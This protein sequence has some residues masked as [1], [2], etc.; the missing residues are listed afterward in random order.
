MDKGYVYILV[1]KSMPGL[2]KIGRTKKN[3]KDRAKEL[4]STTGVPTPF[5][6]AYALCSFR[7]ESLEKQIHIELAN[8]RTNNNRE[9]FETSVDEAKKLLNKLASPI[10]HAL[11]FF[12]NIFPWYPRHTREDTYISP[13]TGKSIIP[14]GEF[15]IE[16]RTGTPKVGIN[17]NHYHSADN[18]FD[19]AK[20]AN[21]IPESV[22][23]HINIII[24]N[25]ELKIN[26]DHESLKEKTEKLSDEIEGL[27]KER[28]E[29]EK[30]VEGNQEVLTDNKLLLDKLTAAS[31][32]E[33][34]IDENTEDFNDKKAALAQLQSDF[35]G[36]P[37]GDSISRPRRSLRLYRLFGVFCV[38]LSFAL[39]FFYI[40][41]IDKGYLS[42]LPTPSESQ[43]IDLERYTQLNDIFDPSSVFRAFQK[44]NLWLIVFPFFA[45]GLA[46]VI[47][48][49]LTYGGKYQQEGKKKTAILCWLSVFLF[50]I[51]TF[52]F[53]CILALQVS[54]KIHEA[55]VLF[56][57]EE[58]DWPID[59]I[60]PSTWD[61]NIWLVLFCGF[62]VSVLL[63][64]LFHF[65]LEMWK[66][67]QTQDV[68]DEIR[69]RKEIRA[70]ETQLKGQEDTIRERQNRLNR[71]KEELKSKYNEIDMSALSAEI[72]KCE[73]NIEHLI[74]RINQGKS[75]IESIKSE[76]REKQSRIDDLNALIA[77]KAIDIVKL[78][79]N[80]SEFVSGWT[81]FLAAAKG[82]ASEDVRTV[83]KIAESTLEKYFQ[84]STSL[85]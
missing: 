48:P 29:A 54:K 78:R 35:G 62:L 67:A 34:L 47:H 82:D 66:E 52:V 75:R 18:G 17:G 23:D 2:I 41:A 11:N 10:D 73:S 31:S 39:Y 45:L 20:N 32:L 49:L 84:S 15:M 70:L 28:E 59:P 72:G 61:L 38:I 55:K 68:D 46:L 22:R 8:Q 6:V 24:D 74:E 51:V 13:S 58:G 27:K 43:D 44:A 19:Q 83:Q 5:E 3:P 1:N 37:P 21:G 53:D 7:H 26:A 79:A 71:V 33:I 36:L 65:T 25:E 80:V 76:I 56:G 77:K 14:N 50:V 57:L 16:S 30:S 60:S 85:E 63:S 40:S 69:T 12:S 4:S 42:N 64:V 9:F 81:K